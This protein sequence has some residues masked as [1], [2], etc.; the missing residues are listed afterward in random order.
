MRALR[1]AMLAVL[2]AAGTMT[3]GWW[4]VPV[5]GLLYGAARGTGKGLAL[6]A[7]A[8]AA[9]GWAGVL[10]WSAPPGPLWQLA[11]RA[12]GVFGLP[13][14]AFIAVTLLFAGL[15]AAAAA[16]LGSVGRRWVPLVPGLTACNLATGPAASVGINFTQVS[17][18]REFSCGLDAL[19]TAYCWDQFPGVPVA[20]SGGVKLKSLSVRYR[21]SCGVG[22]D[23]KAYCWG[24]N[25]V[26]QLGR[27]SGTQFSSPVPVTGDFTFR[28]V[29]VGLAHSCGLTGDGAVYCWGANDVNQ[30]G[31]D[32]VPGPCDV[33]AGPAVA[34][35]SPQPVPVLPDLR[36]TSVSAGDFHSCAVATDGTAY[37][38][39]QGN[40]GQ[41]GTGAAAAALPA[42]VSGGLRF[43]SVSAGGDHSCGLT[44]A[45]DAYCWGSN[46]DLQLGSLADDGGCADGIGYCTTVPFKVTG[47]LKFD[48]LTTSEAVPFNGNGPSLGG[49][50]CALAVDGHA[51]CW[52]LN[53]H[54]QLGGSS[55][56]RSYSPV[57]ARGDSIFTQ[58]SAGW[59]HT[60]GLT[61]GGEI[62]CWDH[63]S[64][65]PR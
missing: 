42:P 29:S 34:D 27:L 52:G 48:A 41:L 55:D 51:Y 12:G 57:L 2:I 61:R 13:G 8:G 16:Y 5:L 17:A 44:S 6:E 26:G 50:S 37:C 63:L 4:C 60:C 53:E 39:G 64:P 35:C 18:G 43:L 7:G 40:A 9:L 56:F 36:F 10:G 23:D 65:L 15:L 54:G 14:W 58:L 59:M 49:H 47:G 1:L 30:L 45:H 22:Q 25:T 24:D 33:G 28:S 11:V 19:G 21:H 38:W 31:V 3:L 46:A 32:S 62:L 20:V